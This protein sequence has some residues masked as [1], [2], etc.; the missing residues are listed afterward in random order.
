MIHRRMYWTTLRVLMTAAL[1]ATMLSAAAVAGAESTEE[2]P[3]LELSL[4]A[5]IRMALSD[6]TAT[7]LARLQVER[8][9]TQAETAHSDLLPQVGAEVSESYK[10]TDVAA[11]GFSFPG[12]PRRI[13]PFNFYEGRIEAALTVVDFAAKRRYEAAQAGVG[14]SQA[15]QRRIESDVAKAVATLYVAVERAQ[16]TLDQ[17]RADVRLFERLR[18]LAA[19]Q[20]DA[21]V[22][23]KLDTTRADVQLARRRQDELVARTRVEKAKLALLYAIGADLGRPL[24]LT[25]G[26]EAAPDAP[27][28]LDLALA[29]ARQ[30]RPELA[31]LQEQLRA[32]ELTIRA[33]HG[34]RL[35]RLEAQVGAAVSGNQLDEPAGTAG[36]SAGLAIPIFVGHRL[37]VAVTQAEIEKRAIQLK[38]EETQRQV[39]QQVRQA[40]LD[41]ES[42]R[43]RVDLS[44]ENLSLA[45][46]ELEQ[47]RDRFAS[48]VASS[49]EV[50]SAQTALISAEQSHIDAQADLAQAQFDLAYATGTIRTLIP[51]NETGNGGRS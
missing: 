46:Q 26:W 42:A 49:I 3:P 20:L 9:D 51:D 17:S 1:V 15:E 13:G 47:A 8:A 24:Q 31:S 32:S 44:A 30:T 12:I 4:R 43:G 45:Q 48:G 50:D 34:E 10:S 22:G 27:Q 16:A 39:E 40:R 18:K 6:G 33:A 28:R 36:I 23:T 35:P 14:V 29:S 37:R 19:D 21:G 41:L 25:D 38:L 11:F 7:R 5:A 2:A